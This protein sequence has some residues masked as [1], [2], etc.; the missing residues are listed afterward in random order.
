MSGTI[1]ALNEMVRGSVSWEY[2]QLTL[3]DKMRLTD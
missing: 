1:R 3:L 2:S